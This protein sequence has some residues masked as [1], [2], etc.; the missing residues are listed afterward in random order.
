MHLQQFK[1]RRR[2]DDFD[3]STI[4]RR[5]VSPGMSAQNSPVLAQSPSHK[6]AGGW[7]QPPERKKESSSSQSM[8]DMLPTLSA[9][10]SQ[11]SRNGSVSGG[12]VTPGKKV[13]LQGMV[14]TNDGLMKMSIE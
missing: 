4:K 5:A 3:I 12:T 1:K 13:G 7:G 9:Q 2:E 10:S 8:L 11:Q 6:D 14:D